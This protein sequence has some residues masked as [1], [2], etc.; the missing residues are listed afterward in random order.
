MLPEFLFLGIDGLLVLQIFAR[1]FRQSSIVPNFP[2]IPNFFYTQTY[3]K[4]VDHNTTQYLFDI[5]HK[6]KTR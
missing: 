6:S 5:R 1:T 2:S 4:Y 3:Y